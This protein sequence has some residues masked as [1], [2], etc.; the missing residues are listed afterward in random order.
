MTSLIADLLDR[1]DQDRRY[2]FDERAGIIE[3]ENGQ[4]HDIAECLAL[5]DLLRAYPG[6]LVGV[7]AYEVERDGSANFVLTTDVDTAVT[8]FAATDVRVVRAVDLKAIVAADFD[9][10]ASLARFD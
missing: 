4:P 8:S 7:M 1:L 2:E 3:F 10:I 6:A 5:I 9:G